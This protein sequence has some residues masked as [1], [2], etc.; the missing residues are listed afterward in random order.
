[1]LSKLYGT[2]SGSSKN[3]Q[4]G[5]QL[6]AWQVQVQGQGLHSPTSS[7]VSSTACPPLLDGCY[8]TRGRTHEHDSNSGWLTLLTIHQSWT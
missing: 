4:G 6:L 7:S 1:V 3:Q 2:V 5:C 8:L